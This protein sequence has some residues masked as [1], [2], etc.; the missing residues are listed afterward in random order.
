MTNKNNK[1]TRIF[2]AGGYGLVGSNM[3]RLIRKVHPNVELTLAGRNPEKAHSLTNEL[4]KADTAHLDLDKEVNAE[5]L[6]DYDLIIAAL[7]DPAERLIEIVMNKQLAYIGISKLANELA[8]FTFTALKNR[9]KQPFVLLGHWQAGVLTIVAQKEAESFEQID[10]VKAVGFYDERDPIGPMVRNEMDGFTDRALVRKNRTW[11]W[12]DSKSNSREFQLPDGRTA[13]GYP[14]ASLDVPSLGSIT[15]APNVRFDFV[16]GESIGSQAGKKASHDL[17][18]DIEGTL[19]SG[20]SAKRRTVISDPNGQAHMTG[21]GVLAA[22]ERVLGLDGQS[23]ADGGIHLPET[24]IQPD[25][26]INHFKEFGVNITH[27]EL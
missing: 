2:I 24:L 6:A 19:P 14:M 11:K 8:P 10:S 18:I 22:T 26:A 15:G 3:A 20:K 16:Q 21:L 27:S 1:H 23:P 12:M 5:G 4:G 13:T 17:Y 7:S 9:P 25:D